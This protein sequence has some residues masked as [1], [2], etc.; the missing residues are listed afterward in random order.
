ML[1]KIGGMQVT[2]T[3]ELLFATANNAIIGVFD[4]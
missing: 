2:I 4:N 1:H 3:N